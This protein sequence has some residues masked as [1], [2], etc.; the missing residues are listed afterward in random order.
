MLGKEQGRVGTEHDRGG[1]SVKKGR[2]G[3]VIGSGGSVCLGD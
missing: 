3:G 1:K 2:L